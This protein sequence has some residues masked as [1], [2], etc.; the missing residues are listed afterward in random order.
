MAGWRDARYFMLLRLRRIVPLYWIFTALKVAAVLAVPALVLRTKL[1]FWFVV[2]SFLFLPVHDAAGD[3][4]PVLPVGWTL[5]FEM[6]FYVLFAVAL[7]LRLPLAWTVLP[8]LL[9]ITL[10]PHAAGAVAGELCNPIIL[11]FGFGIVVALLL[12]RWLM[13]PRLLAWA[14]MLA[15]FMLLLTLDPLTSA[16]RLLDWGVPA[17]LIVAAAV[18]L[19]PVLAARL[20]RLA[21][22]LGDASYA[23]Y[24][25]HGFIVPVLAVGLR[26]VHHH[27]RV[28]FALWVGAVLVGSSLVGYA[29]HIWLEKPLLGWLKPR[30]AVPA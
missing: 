23:I 17:G 19:E 22:R 25:T 26:H 9:V 24:L 13:L 1:S 29:A 11:E 15:A 3:F 18:A 7:G 6:M 30:R 5:S 2:A 14:V 16:A 4:K 10:V 21:L 20:P 8:A 12:G 27:G 28:V